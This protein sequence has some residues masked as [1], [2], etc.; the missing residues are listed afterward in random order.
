MLRA[1]REYW[2]I[3]FLTLLEYR[4][5]FVMW[6]VFTIVYHGVALGAL[7]VTM[8]QFPSMNGW[9]FREMFFLYAL[10]MAG[11][12]LHNTFFF[13][14]VSVPDY[15]REG[16]FDRFLV[17]PLD[18][19]FQVLTVPQQIVPDGLVLAAITLAFASVAA[20]VRVDWIFVIFVPLVVIGGAL[21]DLGISLAVATCSF[22]FIRVDTIR[23]VVMSLEQDFTRYPI[24]IYSRGVRIVLTFVLPFAF[25]NYF[26]AAYFLQKADAGMYLNPAIGLLTPAIGLA[27]V[28]ASYA[29]WKTGLS[30]YQG[31]GS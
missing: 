28:A 24:S 13:T 29:F 18:T 27:W 14:V 8:R 1:Y 3:N 11:H 30:H 5:N 15:V 9:N 6:F 31:T 22:W 17:R 4:A 16:R 7:W 26:P 23:W 19:L 12:E 25:M 10:W 2:R 20:N 21:I